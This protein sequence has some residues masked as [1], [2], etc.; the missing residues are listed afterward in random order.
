MRNKALMGHY[1]CLIYHQSWGAKLYPDYA[2][3]VRLLI[4]S[5]ITK[6]KIPQDTHS[7]NPHLQSRQMRPP[8]PKRRIRGTHHQAASTTKKPKVQQQTNP[9]SSPLPLKAMSSSRGWCSWHRTYPISWYRSQQ[10]SG[11]VCLVVSVGHLRSVQD[12][13]G[14]GLTQRRYPV[15]L[16]HLLSHPLLLV[17]SWISIRQLLRPFPAASPS[18]NLECRSL[19]SRGYG[20]LFRARGS[21]WHSRCGWSWGL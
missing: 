14:S 8:P 9:L 21:I 4:K 13:I 18:T 6:S 7:K 12:Q 1:S 3:L 5:T 2:S 10:K 19:T 11:R 15:L 17:H 20:H 16:L